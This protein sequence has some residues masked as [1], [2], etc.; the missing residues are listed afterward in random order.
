MSALAERASSAS[1]AE[2]VMPADPPATR[3]RLDLET[4]ASAEVTVVKCRGRL[5]A[6]FSPRFKQE[7]KALLPTTKRLVLD[8]GELSY[9]DS[10]GLGAV[11]AI[12]VSAKT[13]GCHLQMVNLSKQV[14]ELLGLTHLLSA[15]EECGKHMIQMP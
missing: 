8:L 11:I 6:E 15:F 7:V 13:A 5:V 9:M 3:Q 2:T 10:S 14:R 1:P 4:K 12:Y